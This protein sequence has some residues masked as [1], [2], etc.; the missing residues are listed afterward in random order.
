MKHLFICL[1]FILLSVSGNA[2][3]KEI[4]GSRKNVRK[5]GDVL[6]LVTPT[7]S[8]AATLI[9]QDWQGLKQGALTGITAIGTSLALKYIIDKERPDNSNNNSFPSIHATVSFAGAAFIQKRYGW[10]WG[11]P[12]Y[13]LSAYVSWSR[14]YGK[15]HDWWDIAAGTAIGIGSG[16][17]FTRPFAKKHNLSVTPAVGD[18]YYG[19]YASMKF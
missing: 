19:I 11:I 17:I 16:Y 8:L 3:Q 1:A 6:M 9:L 13:V 5:S 10:E 14:V 15:K 2:Q 4:S 12:A 18:G 7:A